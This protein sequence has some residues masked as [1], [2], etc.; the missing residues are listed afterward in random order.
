MKPTEHSIKTF[1]VLAVMLGVVCLTPSAALAVFTRS[2]LTQITSTSAGPLDGVEG[3]ATAG[4]EVPLAPEKAG[5]VWV[6]EGGTGLVDE[7]SSSNVFMPPQ[8]SGYSSGSLTFDDM[9][10]ELESASGYGAWVAVDD[11]RAL[12]DTAASDVYFA[13]DS[14]SAPSIGVVRRETA[15]HGP[16][17]F[18]CLQGESEKYIEN[19]ELV[20]APGENWANKFE[21]PIQGIAV[22][23]SSGGSAG[24]VYVA[25]AAPRTGGTEKPVVDRFSP[26]GCFLGAVT[27]AAVPGPNVFGL[28]GKIGIGIAVDPTD[29]DLLV[30]AQEEARSAGT[31]FVDEFTASGE[32]LGRVS[33]TS[34]EAQFTVRGRYRPGD[35]IAVGSTG[36]LY[37]GVRELAE[38]SEPERSVV[39]EFG[40]GGFYPVVVTGGVTG[41]LGASAVLNG[42]V[43]GVKNSKG[44]LVELA[45]CDFE[46]VSE[47][48]YVKEGGFATVTPQ[49]R[50]PCVLESGGS[51]VGQRLEEKNYGVHAQASG[52]EAGKV[53]EVRLV[54][55]TSAAEHGAVQDGEAESFAAAHEPA[56][57][58]V[59]VGSVSSMSVD[60]AASIDPLG[61]DTTYR[62]Q[63]VQASRYEP[64]ASEPYAAG[65]S[66]PVFGAD[67]GSGDTFVNVTASAGGLV[68]GATYH[69]RLL[70]S[71]G[72]GV[73]ASEDGTFTTSPGGSGG[74]LPDG[75]AYELVTPVNKED[76]ED[77][78]GAP[79]SIKSQGRNEEST[80]Y[81]VGYASEDGD[82]FLLDTE[83]AFGSFPTAGE[84]S[85]V[86]SRGE[87]G[88]T[89]KSVASPT[90]GVQSGAP[91]VFDPADFSVVGFGDR[92][93]NIES[94]VDED[95]VGPVGGPYV[96][97]ASGSE[98]SGAA[99][100]KPE[101]VG[102]SA[103][104]SDVVVE[105]RGHGLPLCEG[106]QEVLAKELD[107]GIDGLYEWS[108]G[109]GCVS[110]V[111]VKSEAQG[112][113]LV[114]LCGAMLGQGSPVVIGGTHEAV[115]AD[116]SKIFFTAPDPTE[117]SGKECWEERATHA[118]QLYMRENGETTVEVSQPEEGV[119]VGGENSEEP[120]VYVGA[121]RDG[122]KVFF[123]TKTELTKEAEELK[124]HDVELYE[125]NA[126]PGEGEAPLV[127]VSRGE[128]GETE[129]EG[130]G[131]EN[132]VA[133]S[134]DGS[135]VYF[136]AAGRL[137]S[138][139]PAG[140]GSYLY[141]YDTVT[142][143]IAYVAL[144]GGYPTL[145]EP[146]IT[147]YGKGVL[148][149]GGDIAGLS[150]EADYY[151]TANGRF[152]V[153]PSTQDITG[154]DSGGQQ[155]LYR[156]DAEDG[157]VVCV[158]CNPNGSLPFFGATFTRSAV[159][160]DNP[161]GGP[162]RPISEDGEYVFFDTKESLLPQDTNGKVDVYEWEANGAG[163]CT[164]AAGCVSSISSGQSSS[165]DF[166]L[167]SSSY[168]NA[169]GETV[170]GG[171]VFFG[172]H[173][174]LVPADKDEQGDL[175]D[176]RIDGGFPRPL[177]AGPCEGDACDNPPAAP[178]DPTPTLLAS[179]GGVGSSVV[180]VG[181][182]KAKPKKAA[183]C[184]RGKKLTHGRCVRAKTKAKR[185][186]QTRKA[187]H[188]GRTK[189]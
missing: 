6:G 114:S 61:S 44:E 72:V 10:G 118:P 169:G 119:K 40:A 165:D 168:V 68:P 110:L 4:E 123:I 36:D 80:N 8:L 59:S 101:L 41:D 186:A 79:P 177:G 62:F 24:D 94:T 149:S 145:H 50:V 121:S 180:G 89:F 33:G 98:K 134:A 184:T 106:A 137:T 76:G 63:Y 103:D 1:A 178:A 25:A 111:D 22:D 64:G 148:G 17:P 108:A 187:G 115:S 90:L 97:A 129:H 117:A 161:A 28:T 128:S 125:Y 35:G 102:A 88:W 157:S 95:L 163:S 13:G 93:G 136:N 182:T 176:A 3:I 49:D 151:A 71:N 56:V 171:N 42:E 154:Y 140:H 113:G 48:V 57:R 130:G 85:F 19:G 52:L 133:V 135:A 179:V 162:P 55:S 87:A 11:S 15:S 83:A 77:L 132:V 105:D 167:D 183:R 51:P 69:Y 91:E 159:D 155:E 74:V 124:L 81:D 174:Q 120:A 18:K 144:S 131:V 39:D 47:E 164:Q 34:K 5:D 116:G 26:E 38:G 70:A 143:T 78:F 67:V 185:K 66:V 37:L 152:L 65:G 96:D 12:A 122:S 32:Y 30:E 23:S 172:T 9:S 45:A 150:T 153:F 181:E 175:Y 173:S 21:Y 100:E 84:D 158:S 29:G 86:F 2:Y 27:E 20:G 60:F 75:R 82:H 16:A 112:G 139:A 58:G 109:R 170:E 104:L 99:T 146:S 160:L 92:V 126:D 156:Y 188:N 53:Y 127:R 31:A 138:S 14:G 166:F 73:T 107:V 54:A 43:A 189:S 147:W 141:R 7:F 46:Y 142:D